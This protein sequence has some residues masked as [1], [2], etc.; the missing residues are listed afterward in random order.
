MKLF[1]PVRFPLTPLMDLLLIIVFAQFLDVRETSQRQSQWMLSERSKWEQKVSREQA[2]LTAIRQAIT[3]E[4]ET[5]RDQRDRARA[6]R[7]AAIAERDRVAGQSERAMEQLLDSLDIETEPWRTADVAGEEGGNA[8]SIRQD[9]LRRADALADA[10]PGTLMRFLIA[11]E[12]LLKR[13]EVWSIHASDRGDIRLLAGGQT[14]TFRLESRPQ[15]DRTEEVADRL[16]AAYKQLPEPK[17]LVIVLVSY[18][19]RSVAGVYQPLVDAIPS[20]VE[21]MRADTPTTR[22]EYSVLGTAPAPEDAS[23]VVSTAQPSTSR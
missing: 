15:A 2:E 1:R 6:A 14:Q 19:P 22:F 20:A 11:H 18:D 17:G 16:F 3:S 21:R 12:E 4:L 9:A 10:S 23:P 13:A 5:V 8:A 7:D